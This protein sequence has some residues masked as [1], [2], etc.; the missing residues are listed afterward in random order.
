MQF[1]NLYDCFYAAGSGPLRRP[2]NGMQ[3]FHLYDCFYAAG[4]GPLR[5]PWIR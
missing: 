5:R 3:F 4:S 1:V 2:C